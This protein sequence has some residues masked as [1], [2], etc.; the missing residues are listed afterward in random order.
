M[1]KYQ[2]FAALLLSVATLHAADEAEIKR[3]LPGKW[4]I[5]QEIHGTKLT[6]ES[7]VKADGTVSGSATFMVQGKSIEYTYEAKWVV[8]GSKVEYTVTKSTSQEM[9]KTGEVMVDEVI[10][11]SATVFKYKDEEGQVMTETRKK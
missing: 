6:G 8:K 5:N 10:E 7:D 11:I 2:L 9:L 3:L 4:S 1:L